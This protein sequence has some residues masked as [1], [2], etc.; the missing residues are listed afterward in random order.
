MKKKETNL[1]GIF[2][3][4]SFANCI[5]IVDGTIFPLEFKPTLHG[6]DY[7]HGKG[8]YGVHSL[9]FCNNNTRIRDMTMGYAASDHDNFVWRR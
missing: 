5:G 7:F 8:R 4:Y 2:S 1:T 6:E 9:L 3:A